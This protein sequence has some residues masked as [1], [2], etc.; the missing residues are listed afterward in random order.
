MVDARSATTNEL[1]QGATRGAGALRANSPRRIAELLGAA[2]TGD[3]RRAWPRWARNSSIVAAGHRHRLELQCGRRNAWPQYT[4]Q[5]RYAV[6]AALRPRQPEPKEGRPCGQALKRRLPAQMRPR[7]A[8]RAAAHQLTGVPARCFGGGH[9]P[10][11]TPDDAPTLKT[12]AHPRRCRSP[13]TR[14]SPQTPTRTSAIAAYRN[15][16]ARHAR[17]RQAARRARCVAWATS[18]MASADNDRRGQPHAQVADARLH[19]PPSRSYER[20]TSRRIRTIPTNDRILYQ[21]ARALGSRAGNLEEGLEDA[22]PA[23]SSDLPEDATTSTRRE[24]RRG[25]LLFTLRQYYEGAETGLPDRPQCSAATRTACIHERALY[26][27]GWSQVQAGQRLEEALARRS[28]ACSTARSWAINGDDDL[29]KSEAPHARRSSELVDDTL[30]RDRHQRWPT[31]K[32]ADVHPRRT[33][34]SDDAA[35]R[36]SSASTSSWA[37]C[38]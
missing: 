24:F 29:D 13:P 22:G 31:C 30:P 15:F 14:A 11:A 2:W 12:L 32:G 19:A 34:T 36:T 7:A 10:G 3:H 17:R 27:Q 9:K 16:L 20:I 38:T 1:A 37:S 18:S 26:M 8:R 25:E 5:A 28:S 21:L 35:Q 4:A 33:I 6:A 23:W